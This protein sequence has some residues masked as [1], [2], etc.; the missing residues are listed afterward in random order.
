MIPRFF[1][2]W[3]KSNWTVEFARGDSVNKVWTDGAD[4]GEP[5]PAGH[6]EFDSHLDN[7]TNHSIG[8]N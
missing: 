3:Q 2:Q 6:E 1:R 5:V 4:I 8:M 7:I